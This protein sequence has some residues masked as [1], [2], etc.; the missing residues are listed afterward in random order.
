MKLLALPTSP[1]SARVLIQAREKDLDLEIA[2]PAPEQTIADFAAGNPF[3]RI[4]VLLTDSG[5]VIESFAIAEYLEDRFPEPRLRPADPHATA[6]MRAFV[7]AVDQYLFPVLLRLRGATGEEAE[8]AIEQAVADG[9][10]T[11]QALARLMDESGPVCGDSLSLADCAFAPAC[12][13][14][15]RFLEPH[16]RPSPLDGV[17]RLREWWQAVNRYPSVSGV[18]AELR[19]AVSER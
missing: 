11:V 1:Y 15:E 6:R 12:F 5:P 4:P 3:G 8:Q 18:L 14:L 19:D 16:G 13:Y 2:H 17:P 7:Q 10:R 9:D